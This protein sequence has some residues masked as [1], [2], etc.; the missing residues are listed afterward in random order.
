[1]DSVNP[2]ELGALSPAE[3]AAAKKRNDG[4]RSLLKRRRTSGNGSKEEKETTAL[5]SFLLSQPDEREGTVAAVRA[6][7]GEAEEG[8]EEA[9][10]RPQLKES[11]E[12]DSEGDSV[13]SSEDDFLAFSD[14]GMVA[15]GTGAG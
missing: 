3:T 10:S 7:E 15:Q 1:M 11:D 14:L 12:I 13:S 8:T 4:I 9:K 2:L 5:H 6:I